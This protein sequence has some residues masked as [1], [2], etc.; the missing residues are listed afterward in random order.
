MKRILFLC[1]G[2]YYRSRYA[3]ILFN[4][5]ARQQG[6]RWQAESRGLALDERNPGPISTHTTSR[7][8]ACGIPAD[9]YQRSPMV[10]V[11]EDFAAAQHIVAV[12]KAEHWPA[13]ETHFPRWL[14]Q[15]EYWHV[16]DLD[17]STAD[18]ALPHLEAQVLSLIQ[19]LAALDH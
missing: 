13:I 5:H 11:E 9:G 16:D 19:R 1:S 14:H 10:A 8:A 17:C 3:E 18:E 7:L 12:K 15:V 6:L 4:W 2:N